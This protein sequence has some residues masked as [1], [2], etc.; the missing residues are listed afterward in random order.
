MAPLFLYVKNCIYKKRIQ[1]N[2]PVGIKSPK[3][4][5]NNSAGSIVLGISVF[6]ISMIAYVV[7]VIVSG[8]NNFQ[9]KTGI[10]EN[11]HKVLSIK[12]I[13]QNI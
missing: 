2:Q 1:G 11:R 6:V 4:D 13:L 10:P 5:N 3:A 12:K 9:E 8:Y 7:F